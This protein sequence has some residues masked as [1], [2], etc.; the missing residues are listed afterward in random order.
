MFTGWVQDL[1]K[2][3]EPNHLG[4]LIFH[5]KSLCVCVCVCERAKSEGKF[6]MRPLCGRTFPLGVAPVQ[7]PHVCQLYDC[8]VQIWVSLVQHARLRALPISGQIKVFR[9]SG[10][11]NGHLNNHVDVCLTLF[12]EIVRSNMWATMTCTALGSSMSNQRGS[13]LTSV[14]RGASRYVTRSVIAAAWFCIT[15]TWVW[16]RGWNAAATSNK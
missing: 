16:C 9:E 13:Q 3:G 14:I 10:G 7:N 11:K 1:L 6:W 15:I 12:G 2:T 8:G 5:S 4:G